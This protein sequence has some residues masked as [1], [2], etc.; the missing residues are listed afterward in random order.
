MRR[1][2]A[3]PLIVL[4]LAGLLAIGAAVSLGLAASKSPRLERTTQP[5][6]PDRQDSRKHPERQ[7]RQGGD[8]AIR[9]AVAYA[10]AARNWTPGT[11]LDSWRRQLALAGGRY[12]RSLAARRPTP[13]ELEALREDRAR[14]QATVVV[15]EPDRRVRRPA[16]RLL[17][18]LNEATVAAGQTIGGVTVNEVRLRPQEDRWVVVGWTVLPGAARPG[19]E[20]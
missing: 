14:S 1:D 15:A 4:A 7:D 6:H 13:S 3:L 11:Y 20:L 18:T 8:A 5:T 9:R 12:R 17:V 19:G 10:L 2:P 16:A